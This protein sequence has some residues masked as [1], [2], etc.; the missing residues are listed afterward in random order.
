MSDSVDLFYT[1]EPHAEEIHHLIEIGML[2]P[3]GE[4]TGMSCGYERFLKC[5]TVT[6]LVAVAV[7]VGIGLWVL[8]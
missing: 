2:I 1:N 5:L 8:R 7:F 6:G 3:V 4:D